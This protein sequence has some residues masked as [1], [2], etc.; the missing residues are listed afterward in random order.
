MAILGFNLK[1]GNHLSIGSLAENLDISRTPVREALSRLEQE[2]LVIRIP[3]KGFAVNSLDITEIENLFETRT[4]IELLAV[5]Q[6]A[7]RIDT[8]TRKELADYLQANAVFIKTGK[9]SSFLE[10]GQSFHMKIL[11]ASKNTSLTEVGR[12]ILERTWTIQRFNI[13]TAE[14]LVDAHKEHTEIFNAL[15]AG[16]SK[17]AEA[18]MRKHMKNTTKAIIPRLKDQNDILQNALIDQK[19]WK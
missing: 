16:N 1:P 8:H 18:L 14:A 3:M 2:R 13:F 7:E 12:S 15:S 9:K 6:A 4:V 11:Q 19:L 10:I 5:R 17:Q